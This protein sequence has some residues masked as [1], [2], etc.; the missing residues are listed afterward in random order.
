[1]NQFWKFF[2]PQI[3]HGKKQQFLRQ[4]LLHMNVSS[5][6]NTIHIQDR[7]LLIVYDDVWDKFISP[8]YE[9]LN[10]RNKVKK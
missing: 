6:D 7:V 2:E 10:H 1:M 8:L 9:G 3:W 4:L 5:D